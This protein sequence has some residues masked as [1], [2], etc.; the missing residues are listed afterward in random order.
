[1]LS[2]YRIKLNFHEEIRKDWLN[3]L[4]QNETK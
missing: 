3:K 1:M 4:N 2:N